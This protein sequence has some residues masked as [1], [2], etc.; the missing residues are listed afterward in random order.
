M[1]KS[2]VTFAASVGN[3]FCGGCRE[4]CSVVSS[5]EFKCVAVL[6]CGI[7]SITSSLTSKLMRMTEK[8]F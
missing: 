7:V 4:C 1:S 8:D 6:G 3:E 2:I 5:V